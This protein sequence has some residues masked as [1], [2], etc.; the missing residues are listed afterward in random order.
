MG[1]RRTGSRTTYGL[2]LLWHLVLEVLL[3][4]VNKTLGLRCRILR[5][6][7]Q[8][9]F[10]SGGSKW[11]INFCFTYIYIYIV[12]AYYGFLYVGEQIKVFRKLT[13][14]INFG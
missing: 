5:R 11:K 10:D 3:L 9:S 14:Y 1:H 2:Y 8:R 4:Q 12:M 7:N 6:K 13:V